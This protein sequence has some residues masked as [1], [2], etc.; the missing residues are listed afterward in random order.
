MPNPL[1]RQHPLDADRAKLY[2]LLISELADFAVFLTDPDGYAVSWNPGV[3]RILGYSES[4]WLGQSIKVIFLPEDQAN[5]T[6]HEEIARAARHGQSPDVRWHVR[7]DGSRLFVEGTLVALRDDEGQ[8][9]GFSKVIRDITQRKQREL[10]LRDALA[11]AE[12]LIDTMRLPVLVL[13]PDL[14]IRS[15]NRSFCQTFRVPEKETENRRLYELGNGQWNIPQ[16]RTLLE[17]LLP[18]K[19]AVEDFELEHDFPELGHKVM[20]LNAR[21]LLREGNQTELMLLAFED[22]T[23]RRRAERSL[24]E[25]EK[26][27]RLVMDAAPAIIGYLDRNLR[28]RMVNSAY[29]RWFGISPRDLIGKTVADAFGESMLETIKP[30][31]AAV[32]AGETVD[33]EADYPGH[34][35]LQVSYTPD[36]DEH[37]E[38]QGF[39]VLGSDTTA[40]KKAETALRASEERWRSL[41]E[42]MAE[43]FF[44]GQMIYGDDGEARDFKLLEVNPAFEKLTGVAD[45]TG[46]TVRE[47]IPGVPDELIQQYGRV[48]STGEPAQFEIYIP[49]LQNRWYEARARSTEGDCFAV[50]FLDITERK[51]AEAQMQQQERR[52]AALVALGDRLRDVKDV[53]SV[54]LAAMEIAGTALGVARAGYGKVD[55]TQEYVVVESDW[56]NGEIG[57]LA[58]TYRFEDFGKDLGARLQRGELVAVS[59]V[60]KDPITAD[61][62]DRW[63]RLDIRAVINVPLIEHGRLVAILFIQ[64]SAPR[65]W[66]EADLTFV[67][68]VADRTWAAVARAQAVKELQESEEFNRSVLASTPDC[69]KV[70]DLEGRL[71]TM[72][73]GGCVQMEIDDLSIY[74]DRPWSDFWG[75]AKHLA[76]NAAAAANAGHTSRF[77]G[78][79]LTAKG[80]P[81]WWE[82]VVTPI[83]DASGKPMRILSISRDITARQEAAEERER[84]TL[85]LKRSNEELS[86]FAHI[87]A[88]DLQS[89]L[90][91]VMSFAQLLQRRAKANLPGEAPEFLNQIIGNATRMQELVKALLRFAQVGQGG[92]EKTPVEM[93]VV[94]KAALDSLQ[95]QIEEQGA[96]ITQDALPRVMGDFILLAQVLQNLIGNAITYR[97]QRERPEIRVTG[98]ENERE[99]VIAVKDNGEGIAP[100]HLQMIFEP[101]KRL[102]GAEVPG[103]GLGLA[104][105]ERIVNRH[106]GRIWAESEV[107]VGST[108]YFTLPRI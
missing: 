48:V 86:Q 45:A 54:T 16:L 53:S 26:Q 9:L 94:L 70:L 17:E 101:L 104:T 59:D 56:T 37:G 93:D 78:P 102:R 44:V 29:Q 82:V 92:M 97:G 74:L 80:T 36:L 25:S 47:A 98:T 15:A 30:H 91:G 21:R 66:T 35:T 79:C 11:Y 27:R 89:P 28:Y 10:Q 88:H 71:L 106:G 4:E 87:V 5:G 85:E 95:A 41:F 64:D 75:E 39:V 22:V 6:M 55:A 73:E 20:V 108:F 67:R 81:K 34:R 19:T 68:K 72:N 43:G 12:G 61:E 83:R 96:R 84:L 38:V 18:E 23:D 52:Q 100:E 8:L 31:V 99:W 51:N 90:R 107:G 2:D 58:G 57:T 33:F 60:S 76:E 7:R 49:A 24:A 13:D 77:E 42:R 46:K 1:A 62:S 63:A 32:L 69:V 103:T 3:E 40:R 65:K 50:L 105:C 14:R